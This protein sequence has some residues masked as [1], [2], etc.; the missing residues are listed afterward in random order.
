MWGQR[1]NQL[2]DEQKAN[3]FALRR[4]GK[5]LEEIATRYNVAPST[6]WRILNDRRQVRN[7]SR[8]NGKKV[9]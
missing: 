3:I 5:K 2:T 6:I 1:L 8:A 9:T 4:S 7:V